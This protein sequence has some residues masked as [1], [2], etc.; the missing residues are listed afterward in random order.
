MVTDETKKIHKQVA[1]ICTFRTSKQEHFLTESPGR[2]S[3]CVHRRKCIGVAALRFLVMCTVSK[4]KK[5]QQTRCCLFF[6][7]PQRSNEEKQ[8]T[9]IL[10]LELTNIKCCSSS[11]SNDKT[12]RLTVSMAVATLAWCMRR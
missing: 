6:F 5:R 1:V 2:K 7:L 10:E 12:I 4:M 11:E 9:L 3:A 8:M